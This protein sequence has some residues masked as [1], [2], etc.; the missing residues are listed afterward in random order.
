[1]K[2]YKAYLNGGDF[3]RQPLIC[4]SWEYCNVSGENMLM[5]WNEGKRIAFINLERFSDVTF[6]PAEIVGG[7]END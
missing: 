4:D 5:I 3:I 7:N 1:M 6:E 2:K